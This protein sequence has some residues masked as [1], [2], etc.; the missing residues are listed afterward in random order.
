MTLHGRLA[1][2]PQQAGIAET[3]RSLLSQPPTSTPTTD[4]I[5]PE[6]SHHSD[7]NSEPSNHSNHNSESSDQFLMRSIKLLME[8]LRMRSA[9]RVPKPRTPDIFDGSDPAKIDTY[10]FQCSLY[11]VTCSADFPDQTLHVAFT[12]SYLS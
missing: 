1:S 5:I 6:P 10:I 8:R 4:T 9:R 3:Y 11:I 7:Y 2:V 12:L